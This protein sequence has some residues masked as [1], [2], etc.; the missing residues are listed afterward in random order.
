MCAVPGVLLAALAALATLDRA[1]G[2]ARAGA[3]GFGAAAEAVRALVVA[4]V[5]TAAPVFGTGARVSADV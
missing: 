4:A 5:E 1:G 3:R 2:A